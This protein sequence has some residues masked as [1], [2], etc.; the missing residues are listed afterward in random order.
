MDRRQFVT[1][2]LAT[3]AA[4]LTNNARAAIQQLGPYAWRAYVA[5]PQLVQQQCAQWCWAA[6]TS[7]IFAH[8]NHAVAQSRIVA[9]VFGGGTPC[10]S[11]GYGPNGPTGTITGVLGATWQEDNNGSTFQPTI[12]AGYD[13]YYGINQITNTFIIDELRND[14]PLLYCNTHHAMVV[15]SVGFFQTPMGPNVQE[16]GVLD[17]W[18]TSGGYHLL[19]PA[20]MVPSAIGGQMTYLAAVHI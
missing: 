13:A 9:R 11:S 6:S 1:G 10:L 8:H 12:V 15:V 17:P 2:G 16:V 18:P 7:M 4:S 14:R 5:H 19:S 3:I 20:E